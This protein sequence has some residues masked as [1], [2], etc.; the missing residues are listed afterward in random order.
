MTARFEERQLGNLTPEEA[1]ATV[2]NYAGIMNREVTE[3]TAP[4]IADV[5]YDD[6]FYISQIIRTQMQGPDLTTKAGVRDALQFETTLGKGFVARVWMEYV[7]EG[8]QRVNDVNGKKIV[9]YL[10]RYGDEERT[11]QQ[12]AH[13]LKLEMSDKDLADRLYMLKQADLVAPGS[14]NFHFKGLG[15]P[16][17]AAVF[18]KQFT[19]EIEQLTPD[20][21]SAE[22]EAEMKRARRQAAW[23]KGLAGDYKVMYHLLSAVNGGISPQEILFN[24]TQG[25]TLNGFEK[26][27]KK[28]FHWDQ[29]NSSIV[30]LYAKST[31]PEGMD[32]VAEV[33]TWEKP[34]SMDV[35]DKFIQLKE[36]L[37][38]RLER[39]TA[40]LFYSEN[41]FAPGAEQQLKANDIMYTTLEKLTGEKP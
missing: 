5:A 16:I 15:D 29:A 6:P 26:M 39:K 14:S 33:K 18:R 8:I 41:G 25:F 24:P 19:A 10:A 38:A 4:Y 17:F 31:A 40:F 37:T 30:D 22:F 21:I 36:A 35:V 23:F 27:E 9:L 13:D 28:T 3:T 20:R 2:Y 11:R 7:A 32:L 34:V 12:I 1:L